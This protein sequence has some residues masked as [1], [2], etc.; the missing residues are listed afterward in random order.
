M[1]DAGEFGV[2]EILKR[3]ARGPDGC[4]IGDDA[5][6]W[7]PPAGESL[8]FSTDILSEGIHF[9]VPPFTWEQVGHRIATANLSD[10]AAMGAEPAGLLL[11]CAL[12]PRF[13]LD[14]LESLYRS[15]AGALEAEGAWLAGGDT[16]ESTSSGSLFSAAI[17]GTA[18]GDEILTRGGASPGDLLVV[19]GPLGGARAGLDLLSGKFDPEHGPLEKQSV[20]FRKKKPGDRLEKDSTEVDLVRRFLEPQAR[21]REGRILGGERLATAAMDLSDGLA[22]DIVRLAEQSSAGVEIYADQVPL[23]S[24]VAVHAAARNIDPVT[25]ALGSGEEFELLFTIRPE[26]EDRLSALLPGARI[27]GRVTPPDEGLTILV[28][29]PRGQKRF[30]LPSGGWEHFRR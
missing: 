24:G 9:A 29:G 4:R 28:S 25:F 14:A 30:P 12:A 13:H 26:D 2:I 19:T 17:W 3:Y 18:P 27:I 1:K 7:S 10:M 21:I 11:S 8:V 5:A 20:V 22:A 23:F 16:V 6:V 15:L